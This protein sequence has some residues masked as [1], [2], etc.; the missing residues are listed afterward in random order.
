M[1]ARETRSDRAPAALLNE[2]L[3]H[4]RAARR[5]RCG[6]ARLCMSAQPLAPMCCLSVRSCLTRAARPRASS[7]IA[8]AGA[9]NNIAAKQPPC[10]RLGERWWK[11]R[12]RLSSGSGR[13]G[14]EGFD[15]KAA[16]DALVAFLGQNYLLLLLG[17]VALIVFRRTGVFA[18]VRGALEKAF[19][20][21]WQLTLLA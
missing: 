18:R 6:E 12:N 8:F 5:L 17:L 10:C 19:I 1:S 4:G 20:D 13:R 2:T 9:H 14:M 21:N 7:C 15:V 3:M 11:W 16:L